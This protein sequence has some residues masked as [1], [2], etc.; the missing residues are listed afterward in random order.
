MIGR[1]FLSFIKS[2]P[3]EAKIRELHRAPWEFKSGGFVETS[4]EGGGFSI[5]NHYY[6]GTRNN[7]LWQRVYP[8]FTDRSFGAPQIP[9]ATIIMLQQRLKSR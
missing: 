3:D 5:P 8:T 7:E 4:I 2:R 1:E 9:D 6:R